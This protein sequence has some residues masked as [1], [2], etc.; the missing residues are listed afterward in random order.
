MRAQDEATQ[1]PAQQGCRFP[2]Q[3]TAIETRL[4]GP[5]PPPDTHCLSARTH[6]AWLCGPAGGEPARTPGQT[7]AHRSMS[8]FGAHG[9]LL[10]AG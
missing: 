5:G 10:L 6:V 1:T 7:Q 2:Q 8:T 3:G 4:M 9:H